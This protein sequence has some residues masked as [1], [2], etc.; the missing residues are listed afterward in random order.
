MNAKFSYTSY[1]HL[2]FKPDDQ[3][4]FLFRDV[5]SPFAKQM[6]HNYVKKFSF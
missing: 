5:F 1:Q 3:F 2:T 6:S 4:T